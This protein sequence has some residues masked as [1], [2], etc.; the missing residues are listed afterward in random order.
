MQVL[1]KYISKVCLACT[2]F[3]AAHANILK[4]L[5]GKNTDSLPFRKGGMRIL[6]GAVGRR[7]VVLVVVSRHGVSQHGVSQM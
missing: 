1:E 2:C 3:W 4:R 6:K 5:K 7:L